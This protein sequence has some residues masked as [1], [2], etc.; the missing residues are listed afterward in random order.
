MIYMITALL[1]Y[2]L[3][4]LARQDLKDR[5]LPNSL[6]LEV[7]ALG[8]LY[9]YVSEP[10]EMLSRLYVAVGFCG[11][12]LLFGAAYEKFRKIESMGAGD[13]KLLAA[14]SVWLPAAQILPFFILALLLFISCCVYDNFRGGPKSAFADAFGPHIS[15]A[16]AIF[17]LT[18]S[19]AFFPSLS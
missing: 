11:L 5:R 12:V 16:F 17:W 2:L 6:V 1:F 15:T 4:K 7:F 10:S 8:L 9:V 13:I 18:T 3:F 14:L 19:P